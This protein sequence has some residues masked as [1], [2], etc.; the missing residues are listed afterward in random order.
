M[1]F[2]SGAAYVAKSIR[3]FLE[4]SGGEWDWD[5]FTSCPMADP[6]LDSI[7]R[8]AAAVELPVQPE[9]IATLQQLAVEAEELMRG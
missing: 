1:N 2:Q 5:D 6:R 4:G 3:D 7:R 9:G 8:R